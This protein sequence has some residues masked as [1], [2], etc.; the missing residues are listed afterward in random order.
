MRIPRNFV[1]FAK[2]IVTSAGATRKTDLVMR[3]FREVWDL[4]Q[5]QADTQDFRTT[6][7]AGSSL[8][9]SNIR[10]DNSEIIKATIQVQETKQT[11]L[12]NRKQK[13]ASG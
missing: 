9:L 12:L 1:C 13:E 11:K 7:W 4:T 10:L 3:D 6:V 5:R 8:F 2:E